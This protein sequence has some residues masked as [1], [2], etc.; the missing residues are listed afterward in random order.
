MLSLYCNTDTATAN[1]CS[2]Y[3]DTDTANVTDVRFISCAGADSV[4]STV[5]DIPLEIDGSPWDGRKGPDVSVNSH[6]VCMPEI[7][8]ERA[9]ENIQ[10]TIQSSYGIA[11]GV[12][13]NA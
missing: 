10:S 11:R 6:K 4:N 1:V 8:S 12:A 9:R 13:G 7:T 2:L 3:C 5:T